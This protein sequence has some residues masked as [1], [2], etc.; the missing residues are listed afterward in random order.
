MKHQHGGHE[1]FQINKLDEVNI[2]REIH[3]FML[4]HAVMIV[5]A[6]PG[7]TLFV[8]VLKEQQSLD[9]SG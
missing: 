2:Y 9:L 8:S 7:G 6:N 5:F 4:L 3:I 1:H